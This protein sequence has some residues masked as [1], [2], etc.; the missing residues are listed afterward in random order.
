MSEFNL[1]ILTPEGVAYEGKVRSV[2]APGNDGY[3]G[4]LKD[5][6][7]MIAAI[8]PGGLKVINGGEEYYAVSSGFVEVQANQVN[9]LADHAEKASSN[10]D[11]LEKASKFPTK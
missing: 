10:E 5:H 2:I 9:F 6:A 11:A 7:P 4:V 3:F 8:I 1:S